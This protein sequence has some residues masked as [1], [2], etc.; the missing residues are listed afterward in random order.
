MHVST[1]LS[2]SVPPS[3]SLTMSTSLFSMS[4]PQDP[5]WGVGSLVK[6]RKLKESAR[7][8]GGDEPSVC[9]WSR[10]LGTQLHFR[11]WHLPVTCF[12]CNGRPCISF[13]HVLGWKRNIR[14]VCVGVSSST[15]ERVLQRFVLKLSTSWSISPTSPVAEFFLTL[16]RILISCENLYWWMRWRPLRSMLSVG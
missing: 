12:I 9:G 10:N 5:C 11:M 15:T 2:Q 3:P 1:P 16:A 8:C 6:G 4:L 14:P 13:W 7:G